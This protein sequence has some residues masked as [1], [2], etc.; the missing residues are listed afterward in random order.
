MAAT[1]HLL[2]NIAAGD[3]L[4]EF[5]RA[6]AFDSAYSGN[7]AG[8]SLNTLG[9]R[10]AWLALR[11]LQTGRARQPGRASGA[12]GTSR[13]LSAC[14]TLGAGSTDGTGRPGRTGSTCWTYGACLA[15]RAGSAGGARRACRTCWARCTHS[16]AWAGFTRGAC[17]PNRANGA[18]GANRALR[19]GGTGRA[20]SARANAIRTAQQA[21]GGRV[22]AQLLGAGLGRGTD[23]RY[24]GF[25]GALHPEQ[26]LVGLV[27]DDKA[28]ACR[29]LEAGIGRP[30]GAR[31]QGHDAAGQPTAVE[32]GGDEVHGWVLRKERMRAERNAPQD[33]SESS[34]ARLAVQPRPETGT[35]T[36]AALGGGPM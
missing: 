10:R 5:T 20:C 34:S 27:L 25:A 11:S 12:C 18:C 7:R 19:T 15:R 23:W 1:D 24:I 3:C 32:E 8:G 28:G 16:A 35:A 31:S 30:C 29:R 21:A 14:G 36:G 22:H 17:R 2:A 33:K 4:A 26:I 13:A 6:I 9:T